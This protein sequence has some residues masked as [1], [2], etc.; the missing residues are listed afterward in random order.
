MSPRN[1]ILIALSIALLAAAPNSPAEAAA[2]RRSGGSGGG[3][4][5]LQT[6]N[7][8]TPVEHNN[9]GVELG[10]KGL[11]PDAV[12]EHETA[13]QMDPNSTQWRTNLS[14]AHL[15]YGK[16]FAAR[17]KK[18]EAGAEFRKAM[19][20]DPANAQADAELDKVLKSLGKDP[21]SY[22]YRSSIADDA[23]VSGQY[24][25]AIVEWRKCVKMQDDAIS[26]K[27]LGEVLLKAGKT[28]DGFKELRSAVGR[29]DWTPEQKKELSAVH[30]K[31]GDI[32]LEFALK[33]KDAGKGTKGMQ[34][35]YNAAQEYRRAVQVYPG[36]GAAVDGLIKCAQMALA[37]R[38]SFDNHLFLGGAYLLAGKFPQA[39]MEYNECFKIKGDRPELST[40]RIAFHQAVARSPLA[41]QE[42]VADSVAKIKKLI[43]GDPENARLWYILGRLREA[44]SDY[45]KAKK[46]YDKAAAINP[47]IDP[48]LKQAL[49]RIGAAPAE[50]AAATPQAAR[51]PEQSKEALQKAM[52][53]KEY[54]ELEGM[55][56]SGNLDEAITKL[57]ELFGKDTK[58]GR[59]PGLLGRAYEKKGDPNSAKSWYRI[60][61]GLGDAN[62]ARFLEQVD[63]DRV[64][65]KLSEAEG[66]FK[67]GK[68]IEAK[69]IYQDIIVM[70]PKRA[71]AHR[72]LGDCMKELGDKDG[73]KKEYDDADR[74]D[75]GL[76]PLSSLPD[77]DDSSKKSIAQ[78]D[79]APEDKG[80][81]ADSLQ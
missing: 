65:L 39:Q 79:K 10:Q 80:I 48:D 63:A 70:A 9:R 40:A 74:I 68:F 57:Q 15:E 78:Q 13:L 32:L 27:R 31:L 1:Q 12:R 38:P 23:D 18:F 16:W 11:W 58:D 19:I 62:S 33:A 67:E 21:F 26:H 60:G 69:S 59:Y 20:I 76:A 61:A 30:G 2:K 34:R 8:T 75:K 77:S 43:D 3:G 44:Q 29:T 50:I 45:E 5:F 47:L 7:P 6:P 14:A 72:K 36:N 25:T 24:D 49:V 42:Q 64:Q 53:E 4:V 51:T 22:A 41:S 71:D 66:L 28:V 52:R 37:I 46:S 56:E 81:K 35:L 17:G 54:T 73:A 55:V